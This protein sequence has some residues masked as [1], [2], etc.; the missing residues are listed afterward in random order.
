M[1]CTDPP[2][3]LGGPVNGKRG[4]PSHY[5]YKAQLDLYR[6]AQRIRFKKTD[7]SYLFML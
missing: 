2:R 6:A 3:R 7:Q 1:T 5:A 4:T